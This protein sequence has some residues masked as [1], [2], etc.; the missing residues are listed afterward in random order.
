MANIQT[1]ANRL[2]A[3][4]G[5][6]GRS[7]EETFTGDGTTKR[8]QLAFAPLKGY[9]LRIYVDGVDVSSTAA[10]EEVSG[11]FQLHNTPANNSIIK[12]S[13][14]TYKYFT[15]TEIQYYVSTAFFEHSHTATTTAGATVTL[16]TLP[17]VEEYPLVILASTMAL[18]TLATDASFDIDILSPDGVNIPRSERYRQL[19]QVIQERKEQYRELCSLLGIGLYRIEVQTLRR[20]SRG[21]NRYVPIYRPQEVDDGSIPQRV[22]LS[23]PSYWDQTPPGPAMP[24]DLEFM[25]GDDF[26]EKFYFDH[27]LT[28]W[29]PLAQIRLY[30]QLPADQVGPLLLGTFN[31]TKASSKN[32]GTLDTLVLTLPGSVTKE[33]PRTSYW[34]LQLTSTAG[35][36]KTYLTG[37]IFT[38]AQIT[39]TN[40]DYH[41]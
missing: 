31:I 29:T 25:A 17:L 1:L 12:V 30:P 11:L 35:I 6:V 24:K 22:Y 28:D 34:D 20:I 2:R 16:Q 26:M 23:L 40:G 9:T 41:V 32:N 4:I 37:K 15:D 13:G 21:T 38:K 27:D 5:D 18:Y 3:E 33:L 10:I 14:V 36:T 7:F 19:S 39:T 8:F